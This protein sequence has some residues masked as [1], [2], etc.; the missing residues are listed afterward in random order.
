MSTEI[1]RDHLVSL[2]DFLNAPAARRWRSLAETKKGWTKC[3]AKLDHGFEPLASVV[4]DCAALQAADV[5]A[6]LRTFGS[7]ESVCCISDES[8]E[9]AA[10]VPLEDAVNSVFGSGYGALVSCV[11][12]HLAYFESGDQGVRMILH[13]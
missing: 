4:T 9:S 5:I 12:G 7:P 6:S 10:M 13:R 3:C 2:A 8:D 1:A 11:P